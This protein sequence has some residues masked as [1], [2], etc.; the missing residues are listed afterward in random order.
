MEITE[1]G[2][3]EIE[4][5]TPRG[6]PPLSKTQAFLLSDS[7]Q[8]SSPPG[9]CHLLLLFPRTLTALME[10]LIFQPLYTELPPNSGSCLKKKQTKEKKHGERGRNVSFPLLKTFQLL[11]GPGPTHFKF[12]M[13][14]IDLSF[15][16]MSKV[17]SDPLSKLKSQVTERRH[18]A[19]L[20]QTKRPVT[21]LALYLH[22]QKTSCLFFILPSLKASTH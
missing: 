18:N 12:S 21:T 6:R 11:V 16:E 8:N 5:T 15:T 9:P 2:V 22:R 19:L 10:M 14:K 17:S 7:I 3:T 1:F 4:V 20:H 13:G